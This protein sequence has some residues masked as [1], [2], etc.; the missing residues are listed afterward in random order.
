MIIDDI[1]D[2]EELVD[3]DDESLQEQYAIERSSNLTDLSFKEY[4]KVVRE[5]KRQQATQDRLERI[6][7]Q[8]PRQHLKEDANDSPARQAELLRE[9][10]KKS[11]IEKAEILDKILGH[12]P[13]TYNKEQ[14]LELEKN[15]V[16]CIMLCLYICLSTCL[17]IYLILFLRLSLCLKD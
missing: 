6:K 15:T 5:T 3:C 2:N 8:Q 7:V 9:Q 1:S 16:V 11:E 17:S 12:I 14:L 13:K 4:K 10:R